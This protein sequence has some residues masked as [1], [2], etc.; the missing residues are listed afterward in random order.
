MDTS[1]SS[2]PNVVLLRLQGKLDIYHCQTLK[3]HITHLV[4]SG[5]TRVVVDLSFVSSIDSSGIGALMAA[6]VTLQKAGGKMRL[7]KPSEAVMRVVD[8]SQLSGFFQVCETEAEA[9][10]SFGP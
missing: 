8:M 10:S 5:S 9:L 6:F 7:C 4:D 1:N 3:E 2:A